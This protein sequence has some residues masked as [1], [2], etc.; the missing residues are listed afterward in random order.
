M[1]SSAWIYAQVR[2]V[3]HLLPRAGFE[4]ILA[5]RSQGKLVMRVAFF[6]NAYKPTVM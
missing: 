1:W 3:P 6:T 4:R 2:L 5:W